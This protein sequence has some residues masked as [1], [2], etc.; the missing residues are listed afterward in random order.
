MN[1]QLI[2]FIMKN[3]KEIVE[4]GGVMR[5]TSRQRK[6]IDALYDKNHDFLV[7]YAWGSLKNMSLAE[8][9]AQEAFAIACE[10]PHQVCNSPNPDG[11]LVNTLKNVIHNME[12]RRTV[13][14]KVVTDCLGDKLDLL[15][16]PVNHLDLKL[17]YGNVA[18][19][20]DFRIMMALGP[21]GMSMTELAEELGI[22]VSA[23]KK[24]AERARKNLQRRIK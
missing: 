9:A 14:E 15:P 13:A 10:K 3:S 20:E 4:Y 12:R 6:Q 18:D 19:T 2:L 5:M 23:A 11:W 21:E 7:S 1:P 16:A 17:L 24:R 22:S 8:E